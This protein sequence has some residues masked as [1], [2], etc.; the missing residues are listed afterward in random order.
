M[1]HR[2]IV[3]VTLLA[4]GVSGVLTVLLLRRFRGYSRA[5]RLP[6]IGLSALGCV[7]ATAYGFELGATS[8]AM[9]QFWSQFVTLAAVPFATLSLV[10]VLAYTN[11][12]SLLTPKTLP[13]LVAE[14]LIVLVALLEPFGSVGGASTSLSASGLS[15]PLA[16]T[17][18]LLTVHQLYTL[19]LGGVSFVLLLGAFTRSRGT[20]RRQT[21]VLLV[22]GGIPLAAVGAHTFG[23]VAV[24]LAPATF[25]LT[26]TIVA[27][28]LVHFGLFDVTPVARDV[29]FD[30]LTDAVVVI[31]EDD[32]VVEANPAA[33]EYLGLPANPL[34]TEAWE[35]LPSAAAVL[36]LRDSDDPAR[37]IRVEAGGTERHFEVS[38]TSLLSSNSGAGHVFAFSEVTDRRHMERQF[39]AL[40]ENTRDVVTVFD[41]DGSIKYVSPAIER[42]LGYD[43]DCWDVPPGLELVHPADRIESRKAFRRAIEGESPVRAEF[44][45]QSA[46]GSYRTFESILINLL[47]DPAVEGLVMSSRDVTERRQYEQ[48][49]RVLNRV[50]RHDLRNEMNVVL[51]YAD[52]L[53][54]TGLDDEQGDHLETIRRKAE[55][56]VTLGEQTREVVET[57]TVGEDP[58]PVD[59]RTIVADCVEAACGAHPAVT[60]ETD[61]AEVGWARGGHAF[62]DAVDRL[63]ESAI[64]HSESLDPHVDV[65]LRLNTDVEGD[66][67]ELRVEGDPP[68]IPHRQRQAL[69]KGTETPL[70]HLNGLDLWLVNWYADG[71]DGDLEFDYEGGSCAVILRLRPTQGLDPQPDVGA[72]PADD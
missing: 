66:A 18:L 25:A 58:A 62:T 67:V 47:D 72:T 53:A 40:I 20:F 14:P 16:E 61:L 44:R 12:L 10:F 69:D 1:D 9:A 70:Q 21:G 37:E 30:E 49:L 11:R 39:R 6:F 50:L 23:V 41:P 71:V 46:D 54:A 34:G 29:V 48:R 33:I 22:A 64:E 15:L 3:G 17:S 32:R 7:W 8:A 2:A 51:G 35:V 65:S 13:V 5:V 24:N 45:L 59:V 38:E 42:V 63:L 60:I 68:G 55:R 4:G 43:M 27:G 28:A 56:V 31:D 36:S 52:L 26:N 19:L 57:L